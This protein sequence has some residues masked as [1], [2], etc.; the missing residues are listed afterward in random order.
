MIYHDEVY[1]LGSGKSGSSFTGADNNTLYKVTMDTNGLVKYYA[2]TGSGYTE[3]YESTVTAGAN[4]EYYVLGTPD[5]SGSTVSDITITGT[6]PN[7]W[8]EIGT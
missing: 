4:D 7:E 1:E 2:D 8:K 3:V 5:G 6:I